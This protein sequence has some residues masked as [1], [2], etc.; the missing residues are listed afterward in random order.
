M[1]VSSS[2]ARALREVVGR[3]AG[4]FR[5]ALR[6]PASGVSAG[7]FVARFAPQE[8]SSRSVSSV[9]CVPLRRVGAVASGRVA[10]RSVASASVMP[11]KSVLQGALCKS[12]RAARAN[13]L[14]RMAERFADRKP[15]RVCVAAA[16]T[17]EAGGRQWLN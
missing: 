7:A 17:S 16:E 12:R 10:L 5:H 1:V 8:S 3:L 9:G 15:Q 4:S 13:M 11:P 2:Q 14:E 6:K